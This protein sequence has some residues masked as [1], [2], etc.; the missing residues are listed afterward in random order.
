M[1]RDVL[2]IKK[3]L[4]LSHKLLVVL[5]VDSK[6][7]CDKTQS[8]VLVDAELFSLFKLIA[9]YVLLDGLG[10]SVFFN[11]EDYLLF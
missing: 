10:V 2:T 6:E 1:S 7:S 4:A 8:F 5:E 3:P 9:V 11:Q